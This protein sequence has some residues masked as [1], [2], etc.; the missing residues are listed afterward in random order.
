MLAPRG[1][2]PCP[3]RGAAA[4]LCQLARQLP[5]GAATWLSRRH[6][7]CGAILVCLLLSHPPASPLLSETGAAP[8]PKRTAPCLLL[9]LHPPKCGTPWKPK[10]GCSAIPRSEVTFCFLGGHIARILL[11]SHLFPSLFSW[12]VQLEAALPSAMAKNTS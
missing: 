5:P 12:E 6:A 8:G 9:L 4:L 7:R 2:E 11:P 1:P 10:F 3:H